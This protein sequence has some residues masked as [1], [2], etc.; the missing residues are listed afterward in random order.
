LPGEGAAAT[1]PAA[2]DELRRDWMVGA[3][4]TGW[5][6]PV[7]AL[8]GGGDV[9]SDA[10]APVLESGEAAATGCCGDEVT[11]DDTAE[12]AAAEAT[13]TAGAE[14]KPV[15]EEAEREMGEAGTDD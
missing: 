2:V 7:A 12:R 10:E 6:T 4:G 13:M 8:M 9:A 14:G 15:G 3:F 1:A 11:G 5:G